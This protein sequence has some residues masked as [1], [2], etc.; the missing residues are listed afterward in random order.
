M[1]FP[2]L[3]SMTI[4]AAFAWRLRAN[5]KQLTKVGGSLYI[6]T[7]TAAKSNHNANFLMTQAL[8]LFNT[9]TAVSCSLMLGYQYMVGLHGRYFSENNDD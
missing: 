5:F 7:N 1:K 3:A 6:Y 8:I 2:L 9:S 4:S